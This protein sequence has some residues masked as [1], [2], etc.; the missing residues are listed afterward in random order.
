MPVRALVDTA[1]A[2]SVRPYPKRQLMYVDAGLHR[3]VRYADRPGRRSAGAR[4]ARAEPGLAGA[5]RRVRA[6]DRGSVRARDALRSASPTPRPSKLLYDRLPQWLEA[7]QR[8]ER[9]E[10]TLKYRDEEFRVAAERDAVLGVAH[11][12]YRALT[13]LIAQHRERGQGARRSGV[14]SVGGAAGVRRRARAARRRAGGE[15]HDRAT[16]RAACCSRAPSSRPRRRRK[17]GS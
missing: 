10:L 15:I 16:L 1:V 8:E 13:Q 14:G 4:R 12:F 5:R 6:P 3:G 17:C 2:A 11:G 7:L 9:V